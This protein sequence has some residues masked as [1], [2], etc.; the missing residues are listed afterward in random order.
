M[1]IDFNAH[2]EGNC[3]N[4]KD[5]GTILS[6]ILSSDDNLNE[7]SSFIKAK[8]NITALNLDNCNIGNIDIEKIKSLIKS[9]NNSNITYLDIGYN[10]ITDIGATA[11]AKLTNLATLNIECNNITD[12]CAIAIA[13]MPKLIHLDITNNN[14]TDEGVI[15]IVNKLSNLIRLNIFNITT[16]EGI[17]AIAK[18]LQDN[19][20]LINLGTWIK[21]AD[22]TKI[23]ERNKKIKDISEAFKPIISK[24]TLDTD[25]TPLLS[26]DKE[27]SEQNSCLNKLKGYSKKYGE[28]LLP[29]LEQ[30]IAQ[31]L[32]QD[33]VHVHK[34]GIEQLSF[35]ARS[36]ALTE[37][38]QTVLEHLGF[39]TE[40]VNEFNSKIVGIIEE[41]KEMFWL[42]LDILNNNL[43]D[44]SEVNIDTSV[45][46]VPTNTFDPDHVL[47]IL[48]PSEFTRWE[49]QHNQQLTDL[50]EK[51]PD[52][53][54]PGTILHN[55]LKSGS[56]IY[57]NIAVLLNQHVD[58][59]TFKHNPLIQEGLNK[60][61]T[62]VLTK[63]LSSALEDNNIEDIVLWLS[64]INLTV[65]VKLEPDLLAKLSQIQND[66]VVEILLVNQPLKLLIDNEGNNLLHLS[67]QNGNYQL[68]TRI[69]KE[70]CIN[71]E[72]QN[73]KGKTALDIL[74]ESP[75][76]LEQ[77]EVL[78]APLAQHPDTHL[79]NI[80]E[81]TQSDLVIDNPMALVLGDISHHTTDTGCIS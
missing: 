33:T 43:M 32:Y 52:L 5:N 70:G 24:I 40:T 7:F 31:S 78:D 15:A 46:N 69:L 28:L 3:L 2:V 36:K 49:W 55:L 59:N 60:F 57:P 50:Y 76:A 39:N 47:Q 9:I 42:E 23:L 44:T 72:Q 71:V 51:H 48:L 75:L 19:T 17:T 34:D 27:D 80:S 41:V 63:N 25:G 56:P 35:T 21:N 8:P 30:S 62:P 65:A 61:S 16:A 73:N 11:I 18:A 54:I 77:K 45:I 12:V 20:I 64:V 4:F 13:T 74:H 66:K 53:K 81:Y 37:I 68:A 58:E 29:A 79:S 22:I 67:L 1:T 10:E 38:M 14:I 26:L 6:E